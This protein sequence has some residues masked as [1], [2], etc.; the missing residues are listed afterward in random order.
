MVLRRT[1]IMH[2]S[3]CRSVFHLK[4]GSLN[5]SRLLSAISRQ[6]DTGRRFL[7]VRQEWSFS[8][9]HLFL[10]ILQHHHREERLL[11]QYVP[12]R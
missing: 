3:R 7:D 2:K 11:I 8:F 5:Q 6:Q 10:E 1:V 4:E 12:A 9:R